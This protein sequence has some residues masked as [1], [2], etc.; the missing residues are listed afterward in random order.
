MK[1]IFSSVIFLSLLLA[2]CTPTAIPMNPSN[3]TIQIP[4]EMT[5]TP[6]ATILPTI[7]YSPISLPTITFMP[8]LEPTQA[9]DE[10]RQL[11]AKHEYCQ[12]PCF[13]GIKPNITTIS[14]AQSIFNRLNIPLD[15]LIFK[16]NNGK[17]F[18]ATDF[19][20]R[21]G[22]S[23][24][25]SLRVQNEIID[26]FYTGIG[27]SNYKGFASQQDWLAFSPETIMGQYGIPTRVDFNIGIAPG[28]PPSPTISYGMRIYLDSSDLIIQYDS[29]LLQDERIIKVC[30]LTDNY[31]GVAI[32][33]GK[34][35]NHAPQKDGIP[36]DVATA[37][38]L[39]QFYNLMLH[40]K[41]KACFE[42]LRDE[43]PGQ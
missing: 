35:A 41:N 38:T 25:I 6:S 40:E 15:H 16:D 2:S 1:H 4:M 22:L 36:I 34:D 29:K 27:L 8:T 23:V 11:L 26:S 17:D 42:L 43:F 39:E 10:L 5:E 24:V 14:E 32:W 20:F 7:T 19:G 13:W 31:D 12:Q 30:P 21:N 37:L 3:P 18:Y 28:A 9:R 33:V